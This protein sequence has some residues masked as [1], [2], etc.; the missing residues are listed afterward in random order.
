MKCGTAGGGFRCGR[1]RTVRYGTAGGGFLCGND[2]MV[3]RGGWWVIV[4]NILHNTVRYDEWWVLVRKRLHK[5]QGSKTRK[6]WTVKGLCPRD[7]LTP[8]VRYGNHI[9]QDFVLY[10]QGVQ[11]TKVDVPFGY[12]R[13]SW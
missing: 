11:V 1:D 12:G 13:G 10:L 4:R 7:S 6:V 3:R 5:G 9:L 2:H 8:G